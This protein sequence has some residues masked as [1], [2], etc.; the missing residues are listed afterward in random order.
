MECTK[1]QC[2]KKVLAKG[3]CQRHYMQERRREKPNPPCKIDGCGK[4]Q[5][6]RGWCG[7]HYKRWQA[8]GDPLGLRL[9]VRETL[10]D[11]ASDIR[12]RIKVLDN[13]CHEWTGA[14]A[15]EYGI[16]RFEGKNQK[17]HRLIWR[18]V[19]GPIPERMFVCHSCDNPPCCNPDHLFLGTPEDNSRDMSEKN[20]GRRGRNLSIETIQRI[21]HLLSLGYVPQKDIARLLEI[22]TK[23]VQ[24]IN[25]GKHHADT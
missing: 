1:D 23:T 3:L 19:R 14:L 8:T 17:T 20:R 15:G 25:T 10:G 13:G 9:P 5:D 7:T 4:P 24:N 21:K 11:A 6:A 16:M 18:F 12:D 2:D 22:S